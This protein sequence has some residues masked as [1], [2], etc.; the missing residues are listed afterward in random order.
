MGRSVSVFLAPLQ[1]PQPADM[2]NLV[3]PRAASKIWRA[4]E[5]GSEPRLPL[6]GSTHIY[7]APT[8][9]GGSSYF[10]S[11]LVRDSEKAITRTSPHKCAHAKLLMTGRCRFLLPKG[12]KDT[13]TSVHTFTPSNTVT[14]FLAVMLCGT[15]LYYIHL[16]SMLDARIHTLSQSW[17]SPVSIP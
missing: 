10:S 4:V 12:H 6:E 7:G 11:L 15:L 14:P 1:S 17:A 8:F 9:I 16:S 2:G 3:S 5:L 13:N